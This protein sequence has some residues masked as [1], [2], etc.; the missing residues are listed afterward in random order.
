MAKNT[1]PIIIGA[2]IF[3]LL[4]LGLTFYSALR[5][6]APPPAPTTAAAPPVKHFVASRPIYP[7]TIITRAML[8]PSDTAVTAANPV[9]VEDDIIGKLANR[10]IRSGETI[11]ADALAAPIARIIPANIPVPVGLRAVAIWVD[12]AQTAAGLVDAG[13]RVDVIVTH[14]FNIDKS[15]N[16]VVVGAAAITSGRTIAQDLEVLAVNRSIEQ[17][18]AP[19]PPPAPAPGQPEAA[20]Q[21]GSTPVPAVNAPAPPPPPGQEQRTRVILAAP[22]EVAQRLVAANSKGKLHIT[23]RNPSSRERSP[24]PES[25]EYPSRVVAGPP[26]ARVASTGTNNGGTNNGGGNSGNNGGNNKG[27]NGGTRIYNP[28][29]SD[30][31]LGN[32][33][34]LPPVSIIRDGGPSIPAPAP[35]KE[36]TVIRGTEKTRV[37]VSR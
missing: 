16:Q 7:R 37:I 26:A 23:I 22:P 3:G 6:S 11:T 2:V 32:T 20:A 18:A 9:T 15:A 14:E 28:P 19:A 13:D 36:V 1:V 4:A 5:G 35:E 8:V 30:P 27:N 17:A 21:P 29:A 24:Q 31:P 33:G 10:T 25:S 34:S 12:P